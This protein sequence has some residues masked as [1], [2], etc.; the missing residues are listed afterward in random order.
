MSVAV[1]G[2]STVGTVNVNI[3]YANMP[4]TYQE[5]KYIINVPSNWVD[6]EAPVAALHLNDL[7]GHTVGITSTL[8]GFEVVGKY[9]YTTNNGITAS[10]GGSYE[11]QYTD[12]YPH[13]VGLDQYKGSTGT[14]G[15]GSG[16]A[17]I[18]I[19]GP[20]IQFKFGKV[21]YQVDWVVS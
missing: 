2:V 6:T 16:N 8:H 7:T 13:L 11:G 4:A 17:G 19:T 14:I 9:G 18:G 21:G 5:V 10:A 12:I 1:D 20:R 15:F 3:D